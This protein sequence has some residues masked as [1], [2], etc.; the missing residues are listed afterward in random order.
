VAVPDNLET[1]QPPK[2]ANYS[3]YLL[4]IMQQSSSFLKFLYNAIVSSDV[5]V[6]INIISCFYL[7]KTEL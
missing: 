4:P 7:L 5:H 2:L 1:V 3:F 6:S